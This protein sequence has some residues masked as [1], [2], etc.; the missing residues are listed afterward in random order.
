MLKHPLPVIKTS[1]CM[2]EQQLTSTCMLLLQEEFY[3]LESRLQTA[4]IFLLTA[5]GVQGQVHLYANKAE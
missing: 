2:M 5:M 3:R 4:C 1:S